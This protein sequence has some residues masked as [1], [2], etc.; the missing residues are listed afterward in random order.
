M[1]FNSLTFVVFFL[2]VYGFYCVL[3]HR[4]QNYL[5]LIASWVFYGWWDWRF[6]SLILVSTAVDYFCAL[7]IERA[8]RPGRRQALL[9]T[10][11]VTN[12]GL[13]VAFLVSTISGLLSTIHCQS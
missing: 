12:L 13:L 10:S 1:L 4:P 11:V 7:G 8:A 6:L 5:L 3:R 2:L 9:A